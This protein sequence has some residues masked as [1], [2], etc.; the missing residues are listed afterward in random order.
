MGT[1]NIDELYEG[2]VV[3]DLIAASEIIDA[4]SASNFY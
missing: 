4:L 2:C 1:E 3:G